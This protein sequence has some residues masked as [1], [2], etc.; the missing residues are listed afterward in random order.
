MCGVAHRVIDQ[1]VRD[2]VA[3]IAFRRRSRSGPGTPPGPCRWLE[4]L[5][6]QRRGD[7]LAGDAHVEPVTLPLS[8]KPAGQLALRHRMVAAV[9]HVLFARPHQLDR[10]AGH[11]LGDRHRLAHI[12]R[13]GR[14]GR[15]RRRTQDLVHV[16]LG[17]RQAGFL[18]RP[19]R[20]RPRRSGSAPTPRTCRPC[21]AR[22]RSSAPWWR[23]SG[24]G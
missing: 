15:T 2:L 11:L 22:S 9:G 5:R 13:P 16:A 12:V 6:R 10:R 8:S 3:E 21:R 24:R 20:A 14:A 1:E 7:R 17:D 4:A 23:G 18:G 19:R